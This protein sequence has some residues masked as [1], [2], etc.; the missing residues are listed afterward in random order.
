VAYQPFPNKSGRNWRQQ[1]LEIPLFA[2]LLHISKD[3]QVLEVG[4]GRGVGL[5]VIADRCQPAR[6]VAIDFD[7]YVLAEARSAI[8]TQGL[9]AEI[10]RADVRA[11]PFADCSFDVVIDFGTCYH[12]ERP[13]EALWEISRVLRPGGR[14]AYETPLSQLLS[15]PVRSGGR[16]LPW[17]AAADLVPERNALLWAARSKHSHLRSPR[18]SLKRHSHA[19]RTRSAKSSNPPP[20]S[21]SVRGPDPSWRILRA[22]SPIEASDPT[23]PAKDFAFGS[24]GACAAA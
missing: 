1:R 19:H 24:M 3:A 4:C 5:P 10:V 18:R 14:F 9:Q 6:L 17:K 20:N 21:S 2:W 7:E 16:R 15:H 22:A 8:I 13:W 23:A 11:M 12:V